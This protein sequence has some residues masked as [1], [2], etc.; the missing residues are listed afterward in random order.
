MPPFLQKKKKKKLILKV[1]NPNNEIYLDIRSSPAVVELGR[2]CVFVC[3][4]LGRVND[5]NPT[6]D[7]GEGI[8]SNTTLAVK[9]AGWVEWKPQRLSFKH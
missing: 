2:H 3:A 9:M 4:W 5:F 7:G 8:L 6:A 1:V